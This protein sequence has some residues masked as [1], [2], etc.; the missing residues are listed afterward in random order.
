[1]FEESRRSTLLMVGAHAETAARAAIIANALTDALVSWDDRRAM[2]GA[3][4]QVATLE[5]QLVGLESQL[6]ELRSLGSRAS[7]PQLNSVSLLAAEVRSE[8]A[9]SRS[10]AVAARGNLEVLQRASRASQLRPS[11]LVNSMVVA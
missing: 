4:T 2:V 6:A 11:P 9:V 7:V 1:R 5:M 3:N 10:L 8:L